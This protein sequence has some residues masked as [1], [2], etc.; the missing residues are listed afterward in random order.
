[1]L[2]QEIKKIYFHRRII[3]EMAV[4][5]L[6]ARYA[7]SILGIF[8]A[9]ANPLL[10]VLA[11]AFVFTGVFKIG[12]KN[13]YL[14]VL[15][16]ILP[17]MFFS[18]TLSEAAVSILNQQS[19]LRQFNLPRQVIPLGLVLS[20]FLNFLIGW[21]II[22]P[23]F[24]W[25]NPGAIALLPWLS[26]I[27]LL[28]LLFVF[29]ASLFISIF[30]VFFRDTAQL[31]GVVLMLWLWATPVFYPLDMVAGRF[32]WLCYLNPMTPYVVSYQDVLFNSRVPGLFA[33]LGMAGWALLAL[34][35]GLWFFGRFES[36][37]LKGI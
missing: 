13:F 32:R 10:V 5:Q 15:S 9:V 31:L 27:L 33:F 29:G 26:G 37:I 25:F 36:R 11:V 30:N 14:F 4:S 7:G 19:I 3:W 6:K 23:L 21:I 20:N 17:W 2:N 1:M 8:L 35:F 12:I 16:G 22:Y 28:N 24:L 34:F 18:A